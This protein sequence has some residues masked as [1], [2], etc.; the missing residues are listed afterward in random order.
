MNHQLGLRATILLLLP[1]AALLLAMFAYPLGLVIWTSLHD[2][3]G[4]LSLEA[5][6]K[7][8][9]STLF[10]RV[11]G[12]TLEISLASTLVS[13]L[14]GY[15]LA[16]HL[17]GLEPRRR[18]LYLA[19]VMLPFWTSILVKSYAFGII[20]GEQGI[21]NQA[22]VQIVGE[23][24]RTEMIYNRLG[25]VIGMAN[26]L[27][28]FVV[29]P[30]LASLLA[31]NRSLHRVAQIMGAGPLRIFLSVTLPLSLPGVMAGFLMSMTLSMGMYITPALLGGRKDMMMANLVDFYTRQTLDW[32]LA[33]AIAI[34][35]LLLSAMLIAL[36]LRVRRNEGVMA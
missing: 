17:S 2:G 31:Q 25:V 35:L 3:T 6:R 29:F 34:V 15:L 13:V 5:Y 33:S 9:G 16:L 28:P 4:A 21:I 14:L 10:F 27:L 30:V 36:L 20:L 32:A 23:G 22:L 12:N 19:M 8:A 11:L 18:T 7:L 26:F 24:S 1:V